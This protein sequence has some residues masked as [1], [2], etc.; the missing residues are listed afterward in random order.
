MTTN[1]KWGFF[2]ATG[3]GGGTSIGDINI[4]FSKIISF[5]GTKFVPNNPQTDDYGY[6]DEKLSNI[7]GSFN[8]YA[9][10]EIPDGSTVTSCTVGGSGGD[11]STRTWE[12]FRRESSNELMATSTMGTTDQTIQNAFVDNQNFRYFFKVTALGA[13]E[14]IQI[15]RITID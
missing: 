2:R 1:S 5:T 6:V 9:S 13:N 12:L 15:A 11:W 3:G 14:N 4:N 8:C 10:V 7:S